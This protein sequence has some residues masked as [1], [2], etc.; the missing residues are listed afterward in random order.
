LAR[1][2][3]HLDPQPAVAARDELSCADMAFSG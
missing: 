2:P 1:P 3:G